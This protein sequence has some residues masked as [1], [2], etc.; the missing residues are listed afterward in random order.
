MR[1]AARLS[2]A[3]LLLAAAC[4]HAQQPAAPAFD[5]GRAYEHMRQMVAIGPRP[6]GS[7]GAAA[8]RAYITK[9]L[10]AVGVKAEEQ[11][12]EADTPIGRIKMVNLRATLPPTSPGA[13][14]AGQGRIIVAGHYDTKLFREFRFVGANDG[15]SSTA[16]LIELA[17]VLKARANPVPIELLFLD[18]EEATGEWLGKDH[19]YGSRYYVEAARKAGTLKSIRA[20]ILVD[21][22]GDRDLVIK[23]ESYST[24]WLTD[25]IWSAARRLGR[26]EFSD[27]ETTVEDDHLEFLEAGVPSVDIIDLEYYTRSGEMAWHSKDDTLEN[28]AARSLQAVGDVLLAALPEIEKRE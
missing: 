13:G 4:L 25:I 18:G 21:M 3:A 19:T 14:T 6:A 12:F 9:G 28:V 10:A 16:F 2:G 24:P 23:R 15:G 20:M 8:T 7:P 1:L 17:R 26:P 22:I 27:V 11:P 5:G